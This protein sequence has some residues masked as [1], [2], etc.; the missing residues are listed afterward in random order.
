DHDRGRGHVRGRGHDRGHGRGRGH[1][2]SHGG[3]H[4]R[5]PSHHGRNNRAH[6][7]PLPGHSP[8]SNLAP[9]R[10]RDRRL[11]LSR[12]RSMDRTRLG[13]SCSTRRIGRGTNCSKAVGWVL[14]WAWVGVSVFLLVVWVGRFF[15]D[16]APGWLW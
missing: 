1:G 10:D 15:T 11:P 9:I 2:Y 12:S 3:G 4:D 14:Y 7:R 16:L 6:R 8:A 13:T 5:G